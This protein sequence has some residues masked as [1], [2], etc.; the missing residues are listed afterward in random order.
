MTIYNPTHFNSADET[1]A[2][3]L[4]QENPFA[5]LISV[6]PGAD[7][8]VITQAP[9]VCQKSTNGQSVPWKLLGHFARANPHSQVLTNA[10]MTVIF[11]G[12]NAYLS[13]SVY[14]DLKR[15]PTWNYLSVHLRTKVVVIDEFET[16]D[17]LLKTLIA[18]HEPQ[19]AD[20]WR[21]LD[22]KYQQAM[23]NAIVGFE[24]EV[25][26]W[27]CKLKLNQHRPEAHSKMGEQLAQ[28]HVNGDRQAGALRD[29]MLHLGMLD[30][31]G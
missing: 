23:L 10:P 28:A 6:P 13:P 31:K 3:K 20:Q 11:Y 30:Q 9:I 27:Q 22:E 2:F 15:V 1:L 17:R 19:Y 5:T 18:Q 29:W 8:P 26:S 24:L 14:P 4:M 16:K 21:G 25:Q 7:E 12:P